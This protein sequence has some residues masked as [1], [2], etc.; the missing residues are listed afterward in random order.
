MYH[1]HGC[2]RLPLTE[3]PLHLF[4]QTLVLSRRHHTRIQLYSYVYISATTT[5][6]L[7]GASHITRTFTFTL[8]LDPVD[9]N[10]AWLAPELHSLPLWTD[11][12][13]QAASTTRLPFARP[14][15][16]ISQ[17]LPA[18]HLRLYPESISGLWT[19]SRRIFLTISSSGPSFLAERF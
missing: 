19:T 10:S 17:R 15:T 14:L 1:H 9:F 16:L 5:H 2:S 13:T 4:T 6:I 11:Y 7:G 8:Q 12:R 18:P 3:V